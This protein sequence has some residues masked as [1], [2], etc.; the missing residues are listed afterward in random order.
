[1]ARALHVVPPIRVSI[2]VATF[3]TDPQRLEQLV[4]SVAAQTMPAEQIELVF[5]DD[6]S[7][8]DTVRRLQR[9]ARTRAQ[10]LVR[11]IPN[12]GWAGRPRNVGLRLA[13]GTYVLFMD[14]D[15]VLFPRALE[16]AY[17][18][19]REHRADIVNGKEVRTTG[20]S[21]G[22]DAF[23]S[24]IPHAQGIDPN[25]LI[26]MTP[27]KLYRRRFLRR[28]RLLFREG[29]RVFWEDIYFNLAA[30]TRGA[31]VAV[32]ASYPFYHWV[33]TGENNSS[34]YARPDQ[35]F[36]TNLD[37]LLAFHADELRGI[38]GGPEQIVHQIRA[39]VLPF[40]GPR[41]LRLP[42]EDAARVFGSARALALRYAPAERDPALASVQR[43]QLEL[44]RRGDLGQQQR[45]AECDDGI[46]AVPIV[47][48]VEWDGPE[49][50]VSATATLTDAAGTPVRLRRVGDGWARELP[51]QVAAGLSHDAR[52]V[53]RDLER[54]VFVLSVKGRTT[55]STWALHGASEVVCSTDD[56]AGSAVLRA[57][58][59]ARFDPVA[60]AAEHD[61]QSDSVFDFAAR[62]EALGYATHLALRGGATRPA[63]LDGVAALAYENQSGALSLD[64][65]A[66]RSL[67]RMTRPDP[68]TA[69]A[70]TGGDPGTTHVSVRLPLPGVHCLGSTRLTGEVVLPEKLRLPATL[71]AVDGRAVL[72]FTGPVPPGEHAMRTRFGAHTGPTGL[73]LSVAD[74]RVVVSA[75]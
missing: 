37:D 19:G 18:Y 74:G 62:F 41:L 65:Q 59:V 64:V 33:T 24:D 48:S 51:P 22:W 36:W 28:H 10:V 9:Y 67:A 49:L 13:H 3:N 4:Q 31:R 34:S 26:P 20:W 16:R 43:C 6:G 12:S 75:P 53:T 40:V 66:A 8:D 58:L 46:T 11:S 54:A 47:E 23:T 38:V 21:W 17:A 52:D 7:T 15:D 56:G 55:R 61:L 69:V 30:F 32:L 73:V 29:R 25:P 70:T 5:V 63:L 44:L 68:T 1:M 2:I 27:H 57:R 72:S 60:F 45:L 39:R 14:H 35:E 50:V 42:D 71:E